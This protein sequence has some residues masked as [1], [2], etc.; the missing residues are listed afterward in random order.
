VNVSGGT[1]VWYGQGPRWRARLKEALK[2]REE[3]LDSWGIVPGVAAGIVAALLAGFALPA[4]GGFWFAVS[5]VALGPAVLVL[6]SLR[7]TA[8]ARQVEPQF[9]RGVG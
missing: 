1:P 3:N 7:G 9:T 4:V 2:T 5:M 8:N 6:F